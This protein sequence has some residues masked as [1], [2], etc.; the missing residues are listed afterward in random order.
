MHKKLI[1][2]SLSLALILSGCTNKAL[3]K[4]PDL[5]NIVITTEVLNTTDLTSEGLNEELNEE[6]EASSEIEILTPANLS[7]L[8]AELDLIEIESTFL[9][10]KLGQDLTTVELGEAAR[11]LYTLWDDELNSLWGRFWE[12][13]DKETKDKVLNEQRAWINDKETAAREASKLYEGGSLAPVIELKKSASITRL[14]CYDI[15]SYLGKIIGQTVIVPTINIDGFYADTQGTMEVYSDLTIQRAD[16]GFYEI[17][18]SLYRLATLKGFATL[19][20]GILKFTDESM[21]SNIK[22]DIIVENESATFIIT[23]SDWEYLTVGEKYIFDE[24][25]D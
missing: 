3:S 20:N 22:G 7:E 10:D 4:D 18:V 1:I 12:K 23:E 5:D 8:A 13:A 25:W 21:N 17:E 15:A 24:K 2:L 19:E 6:L 11:E 9:E 16:D 14:R